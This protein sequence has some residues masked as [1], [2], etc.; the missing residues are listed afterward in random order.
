MLA[1]LIAN[2]Q[3]D[4]TKIDFGK[5]KI[6]ILTDKSSGTTD[7]LKTNN[8]SQ[9]GNQDAED[10]DDN[11]DKDD[12]N[13]F[14]SHW[15]GIGIGLNGY[16]NNANEFKPLT[17]D[18]YMDLNQGKSWSV[19]LNLI[20]TNIPLF[21]QYAGISTGLGLEFDNYRFSHNI[22]LMDD[23]AKLYAL[24][25]TITNYKKNKMVVTWLTVPLILE[26][27][28]PTKDKNINLG[29][30][31]LGAIRIGSHTK[32]VYDYKGNDIKDKSRGDYHMN[33]FRYGLTAQLGYGNMGVFVN[34]SLSSLFK[35]NEGPELYPWTAGIHMAF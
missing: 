28:V 24:T 4:T 16:L 1:A 17:V 3:Y 19:S 11:D 22:I 10:N 33:W 23:S 25:D 13:K 27:N 12:E 7:S 20:E 9:E 35:T 30:G 5:S 14:N 15:A 18:N 26:F 34:Y 32:L 21:K 29:V 2:A 6:L 31:L 8:D